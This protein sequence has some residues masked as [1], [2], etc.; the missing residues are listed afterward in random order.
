MRAARSSPITSTPEGALTLATGEDRITPINIDEEMKTSYLLYSM[1]VIVARALPDVRDGL[2]PVQ[3]RILR[4]MD[5]LNLSP[6]ANYRKSAKVAGDTS[7][8]YHPH[9]EQVIYP[10]I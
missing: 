2:K 8:N 7:G 6:N 1:S 4:A 5:D 9:G 3:R 10:T